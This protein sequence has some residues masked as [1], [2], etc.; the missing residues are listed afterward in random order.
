MNIDIIIPCFNAE[1]YLAQAIGSALEQTLAPH[2]IIVVDDGSTDGS[3]ALARK[4]EQACEGQVRVHSERSGNAARTRNIG[5]SLSDADALMF[6]DADDVL[7]PDALA[8]LAGALAQQPDGIAACP[9]RRLKLIDGTWT[10]RPPSCAPRRPDQDALAAWLTGWYYPPCAMLW[11]RTAFVESGR[12]DEEI[13]MNQDGDLV[14]RALAYGFPLQEATSGTAYYRA[15]PE[16]EVSLSSRKSSYKG[17]SSRLTVIEKICWILEEKGQIDRYRSSIA[18]ALALVEQNAARHYDGLGQQARRRKQ[19]YAPAI[20]D[21]LAER[22]RRS[23]EGNGKLQPEARHTA[24]GPG[25][26]CYGLDR[27][28]QILRHPEASAAGE[29]EFRPAVDRRPT[30]SVIIPVFNRAHLLGRTL[31][32]VVAQSFEDF[33]VLVVDDGSDDD[34]AAVV[35]SYQDPRLHYKRQPENKGVAAARNRGLREAKGEFIAFLDDDDEWFPDKLALQVDL[36]QHSSPDVGL[37]Y[38][39]VETVSDAGKITRQVPSARGDLYPELLVRNVF[40]GGGSNIMIR[41]NVIARVGYFDES[42]PAI[43]DYDY[44]LRITRWYRAEVISTP[45]IR[46]NDFRSADEASI[47]QERRS[48]NIQA[49]L[50]ARARFFEKYG[51][52]MRAAGLAHHFLITSARRCLDPGWEDVRGARRLAFQAF[53]LAPTAWGARDLLIRTCGLSALRDIA[54]RTLHTLGRLQ[55]PNVRLRSAERSRR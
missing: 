52:R 15:L 34:P 26:I 16:G 19:H 55:S 50:A 5:A 23:G 43:E 53:L 49:N 36:L 24:E 32:S 39:G 45:L 51:A 9:W 18:P 37:V 25:E 31:D 8:A 46:Y 29:R 2:Q 17:L 11:S 13:A 10:S 3:L 42:L 14:M 30:V 12:W 7:A 38:T 33:E 27:A 28:E 54:H 22:A 47:S 41:R 1:A 48:L 44:W 21:R 6:L 35:E 40:H 4:F 20:W